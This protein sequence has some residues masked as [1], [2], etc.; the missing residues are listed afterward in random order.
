MSKF[1]SAFFLI[2]GLAFALP[3]A[4]AQSDSSAPQKTVKKTAKKNNS[5]KKKAVTKHEE[6]SDKEDEKVDVS[7]HT[8]TL[9]T[10]EMGD[11]VTILKKPNDDKQITVRWRNRLHNLFRVNTTTGADRFEGQ[12]S[13]LVWVGIPSKGILLDAHK[14]RQLANECKDAK[15]LKHST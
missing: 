12:K 8:S 11:K 7:G 9:Y 14:G 10:C 15:Q 13:G 2:T 5:A 1:L 4:V 3:P 6:P